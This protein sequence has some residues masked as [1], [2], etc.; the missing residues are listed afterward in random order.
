MKVYL[1]AQLANGEDFKGESCIK[2]CILHQIQHVA[3]YEMLI[4]HLNIAHLIILSK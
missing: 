2:L 1:A 4:V 3:I